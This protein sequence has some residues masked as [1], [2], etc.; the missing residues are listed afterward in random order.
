MHTSKEIRRMSTLSGLNGI[1]FQGPNTK[2]CRCRMT[3]M[4]VSRC[5]IGRMMIDVGVD[6][7]KQI[8]CKNKN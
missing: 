8:K 7:F 2:E 4:R 3:T 5:W 1:D 6:N